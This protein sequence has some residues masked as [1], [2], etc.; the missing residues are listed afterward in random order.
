[1]GKRSFGVVTGVEETGN[2]LT[3]VMEKMRPHSSSGN[4]EFI[5]LARWLQAGAGLCP[6]TGR[7]TREGPLLR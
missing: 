2:S 4:G 7:C 1:M 5:W 3:N 6:S